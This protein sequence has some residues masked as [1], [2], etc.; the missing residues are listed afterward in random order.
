MEAKTSSLLQ[1]H[2]SQT[3]L[4]CL[5]GKQRDTAATRNPKACI[6]VAMEGK[7]HE[8]VCRCGSLS[9]SLDCGV[10]AQKKKCVSNENKLNGICGK[11]GIKGLQPEKMK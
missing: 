1:R 4:C 11:A 9:V 7:K 5:S 3:I 10:H 2:Y 6:C 8:K